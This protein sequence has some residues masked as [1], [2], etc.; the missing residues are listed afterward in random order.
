[1]GACRGCDGR[2]GTRVSGRAR[3]TDLGPPV[4]LAPWLGRRG[5]GVATRLP[6]LGRSAMYDTKARQWAGLDRMQAYQRDFL[7]FATQIGVLRFGD[8]TLK[9]GRRSPYF[10]NAGLFDT[11]A[12][13]ARL[14]RA[15]AA[16]SSTQASGSTCSTA[17][18]TRGS[19]WRRRPASPL[20]RRYG[21][22]LPYAFNRKEAKDHG[23]GGA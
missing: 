8:F 1:M 7:D 13:L 11:G 17:R 12:R 16:A 5:S 20:R 19:R 10:F 9:S 6:V 22:D 4:E 21:R 2:G 14:A 15:Y 3:P 18:P 23:E